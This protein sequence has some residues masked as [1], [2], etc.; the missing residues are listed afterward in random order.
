MNKKTTTPLLNAAI[1]HYPY[2]LCFRVE[3]SKD[4]STV[5]GRQQG[6]VKNRRQTSTYNPTFC[7]DYFLRCNTPNPNCQPCCQEAPI[8]YRGGRGMTHLYH[9]GE[10]PYLS[11]PTPLSSLPT[12]TLLSDVAQELKGQKMHSSA[13]VHTGCGN[14]E[15]MQ[16][17]DSGS[18]PL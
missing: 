12:R 4:E 8:P 3:E 7:S 18:V 15:K 14:P 17:S 5:L 10:I 1:L 16:H 13:T 6:M 11:T 2:H 9:S